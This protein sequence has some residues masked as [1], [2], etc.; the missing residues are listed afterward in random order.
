VTSTVPGI[1]L[2]AAILHEPDAGVSGGFATID[3]ERYAK[4][5]NV[6]R[7][8]PFLMNV[9]SD[10]DL[11]LFAGSNGPFTTGRRSPDMALFPYRTADK[12]LEHA[13][14][15]GMLTILLVTRNGVTSLWEPW[16]DCER[17]YEIT[18][19]LYKSVTGTSLVFEEIN[20][21]LGLSFRAT[22]AG[23]DEFGLARETVLENLIG[24]PATVRY[25]DGWHQLIPPGVT[26]DV[27]AR[28]SYL[29]T[30]YMRHERVPGTPLAI[31]TLNTAIS[32]RPEPSESLRAAAAWSV[33]HADPVILLSS[34]QVGAFRRGDPVR[35]EDEVRGEIGA[36]LVADSVGLEDGARHRWSTVGDTG[37][38]HATLED[39]R[40]RLADPAPLARSLRESVAASRAGILR[41]VAG[42]D[43]LQ[44]TADEAATAHHVASVLYL[45]LIHI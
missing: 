31:Y 22:L 40:Y 43:A 24:E 20:H 8:P 6:D 26:Q 33:G 13:D 34:R 1:H 17:T 16:R 29:A 45:S 4:I 36:Y 3:G 11:W 9:V 38:D 28:L 15:G 14:S 25:L 10:G 7:M 5:C 30:G 27:H 44:R 37:L 21:S 12:I 42:A 23:C 41:R 32:D 18:R 39:L 35:A 2:G 19:N